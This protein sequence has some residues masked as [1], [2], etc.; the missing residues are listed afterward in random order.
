MYIRI[1]RLILQLL[2]NI[3]YKLVNIIIFYYLFIVFL[4]LLSLEKV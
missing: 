3:L 4:F 2:C 1:I